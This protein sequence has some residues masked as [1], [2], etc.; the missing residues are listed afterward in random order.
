MNPFRGGW[1]ILV[2]LVCAMVLVVGRVDAAPDW[3]AWLRPDWAVAVMFYWGVAAP[4]RV[5]PMSAWVVGLFFDVLVA[6]PL[7]LTG[8]CLAFA[9]YI[10][11]RFEERLSLYT[12]WQQMAVVL[13]VTAIIQVIE[14][15]A[16][17]MLDTEWST[18]A[19]L[20]TTL[21]TALVYPVVALLLT[22]AARRVQVEG[23]SGQL[24]RAP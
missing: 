5:G 12:V 19:V 24:G 9:T 23:M 15:T 20:G 13:V 6:G 8:I 1:L 18:W 14:R 16:L 21:T 4:S 10:A 7:G 2:S 17:F 11:K 22:V 3:L